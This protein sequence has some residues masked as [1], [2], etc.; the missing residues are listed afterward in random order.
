[1]EYCFIWTCVLN[2]SWG[3][4]LFPAFLLSSC[5]P[6]PFSEMFLF[7][8][9]SLLFC[10]EASWKTGHVQTRDKWLFSSTVFM[11]FYNSQL[12]FRD[13]LLQTQELFNLIS[14]KSTASKPE[15]LIRCFWQ[16]SNIKRKYTRDRNM[17]RWSGQSTEKKSSS[18]DM[19][20]ESQSPSGDYPGR[21]RQGKPKSFY[22]DISSKRKTQENVGLLLNGEMSWWQRIQERLKFFFALVFMDNWA[23]GTLFLSCR[24][25]SEER[26]IYTW[27]M[28][29]RLESF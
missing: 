25:K 14:R 1:M 13:H 27:W 29:I 15:R 5:W 21:D 8:N 3:L 17:S 10:P 26:K 4:D 7:W 28:I 24:R 9:R 19:E 18:T 2:N 12:I 23:P 16:N 11:I 6:G 22:K 20:L